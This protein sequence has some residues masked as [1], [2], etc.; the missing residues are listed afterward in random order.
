MRQALT[1]AIAGGKQEQAPLPDLLLI[2]G[3]PGQ[4]A[5]AAR[6][7]A[8]LALVVPAVA[9]VAKG[10]DRRAGQ[11][12]IFLL[13][14]KSAAILPAGLAGTAP[15][16]A[17]ARRGA[18]LCDQRP[19]AEPCAVARQTSMLETVPG[20]GPARRRELLQQFG[21]LQGVLRAGVEDLAQV[22]GIG[23]RSRRSIFEHLHPGAG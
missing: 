10:A 3:G 16:P 18:S 8:E 9:G 5:E 11:E 14:R 21:G 23:P 7:L 6:V 17:C 4:L 12:R 2:D 19:S 22:P 1:R 20:L 13:G 15:D